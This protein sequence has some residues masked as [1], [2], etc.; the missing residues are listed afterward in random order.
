MPVS[1]LLSPNQYW[2]SAL[3][4]LQS[5]RV[6]WLPAVI[7]GITLI[8]SLLFL[9]LTTFFS[10]ETGLFSVAGLLGLYFVP[11]LIRRYPGVL[12]AT[13]MGSLLYAA[14][15]GVL[16]KADSALVTLLCLPPLASFLIE[17][18]LGQRFRAMGFFRFFLLLTFWLVFQATLWAIAGHGGMLKTMPD[19]LARHLVT[20][21][22]FMAAFLTVREHPEFLRRLKVGFCWMMILESLLVLVQAVFHV[23]G[24]YDEGVFQ[25]AG[26]LGNSTVWG[27]LSTANIA[28]ITVALAQNH[29][30]TEVPQ[31]LLG[32]TLGLSWLSLLFLGNRLGFLCALLVTVGIL[33]AR[34]S[35][36]KVLGWSLLASLLLALILPMTSGFEEK[37]GVLGRLD[38]LDT[39]STRFETWK[40]LMQGFN[41]RW[42]WLQISGQGPYAARQF[43]EHAYAFR[44]KELTPQERKSFPQVDNLFL[45]YT[46]DYGLMA[47]LLLVGMTGFMIAF[48]WLAPVAYSRNLRADPSC[49]LSAV[50][51][52]WLGVACIFFFMLSINGIGL[53]SMAF[54]AVIGWLTAE[55]TC[56]PAP[57]KGVS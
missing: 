46:Y 35:W 15:P 27:F 20:L 2:S 53:R 17:A 38:K 41:R 33:L 39:L 56:R 31:A 24:L 8:G 57:A 13:L 16:G 21:F 14:L 18:W 54:W 22:A 29:R 25:P 26:T 12:V 28:W 30:R 43:I 6:Q 51:V 11:G 36:R 52:G 55:A 19:V 37:L 9:C 49:R 42:G 40:T 4:R 32:A 45:E 5:Q 23:G 47:G 50:A 44:S 10:L 1:S 48:P 3:R 34:W 7:V